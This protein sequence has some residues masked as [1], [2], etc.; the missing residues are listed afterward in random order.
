M[1][2]DPL[3]NDVYTTGLELVEEGDLSALKHLLTTHALDPNTN[4]CEFLRLSIV[5]NHSEI[6][7]YLLPFYNKDCDHSDVL[8]EACSLN[9]TDFVLQLIPHTN[10]QVNQN[11]PLMWAARNN[12]QVLMDALLPLSN[13]WEAM[14]QV[15]RYAKLRRERDGLQYLRNYVYE[16]IGA[17]QASETRKKI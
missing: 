16:R 10:P 4:E 13:P 1:N 7:T 3:S 11:E 9:H 2:T 14:E 8:C 12:N 17:Q 15:E 6:F 5:Y